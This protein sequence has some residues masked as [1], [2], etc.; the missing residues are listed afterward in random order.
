MLIGLFPE[1][2]A[3]QKIDTVDFSL[4]FVPGSDKDLM[5][6]EQLMKLL[7]NVIVSHFNLFDFKDLFNLC[8]YS[9]S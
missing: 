5:S 9:I 6:H 2:R 4:D 8:I 7:E 1:L 3:N